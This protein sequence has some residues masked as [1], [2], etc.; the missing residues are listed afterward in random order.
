MGVKKNFSPRITAKT[1]V[2]LEERHDFHARVIAEIEATKAKLFAP[3][4]KFELPFHFLRN[5][6]PAEPN[7][8]NAP[9]RKLAA[10]VKKA[11]MNISAPELQKRKRLQ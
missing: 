9:T 6:P 2:V 8:D 7:A 11:G 5:I 10:N 4:P 3:L 1:A